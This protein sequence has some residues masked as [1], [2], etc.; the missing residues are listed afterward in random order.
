MPEPPIT[1]SMTAALG[2]FFYKPKT[3]AAQ[4]IGTGRE[5]LGLSQGWHYL[6]M[7]LRVCESRQRRKSR[8]CRHRRAAETQREPLRQ[9]R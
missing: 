2:G 6:P 3:G 5:V 8:I 1:V 4:I 7:E 9:A